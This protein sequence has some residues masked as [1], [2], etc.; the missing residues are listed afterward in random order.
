MQQHLP[1]ANSVL[2]LGI[3]SIVLCCC[4]GIVGC[5]LAIVAIILAN[6]DTRLF[7][8]NPGLY[9]ESSYR[10]LRSGRVCAIIGVCLSALYLICIIL[11]V[12]K[13][14]LSVLLH[15]HEMQQRIL[16]MQHR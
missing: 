4:Y 5:I 14:G 3:L 1:S 12:V 6:R 15:P 7:H 9:T 10:N 11:F 2:V 13:F 8:A 16:E